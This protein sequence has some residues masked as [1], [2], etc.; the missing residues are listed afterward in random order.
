[1]KVGMTL[2]VMEPDLWERGADTLEQWSR[3]IDEGPFASL[4][5]G[6]RMA[7]DN[8]DALTLLG[9]VAAWTE[10]VRVITTVIVPQLHEPVPLAKALA[11]ADQLC[12]GRLSVGFGV[13]GR[14]E[15]YRAASADLAHPDHGRHGRAGRGDAP[16]VGRREGHR[17]GA[18]GRPAAVPNRRAPS[19]SSAP[20]ARRPSGTPPPG[21]TGS[22]ASPSTSIRSPPAGSSTWPAAP[23]PTPAGHRPGSPRRSGSRSTTA[24][25]A[26]ASRCTGTCGTT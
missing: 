8:P 11:T 13:G 22:P 26:R 7:F 17:S 4:C 14:E 20:W 2:P 9:A 16:G 24:T 18:P 12:R 15:D 10:R 25:G 6:E 1:M 21:P 23:G 3:A 19:C 5:F